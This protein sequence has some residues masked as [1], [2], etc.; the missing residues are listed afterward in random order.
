MKLTSLTRTATWKFAQLNLTHN[1]TGVVPRGGGGRRS[2]RRQ[3]DPR[4]KRRRRRRPVLQRKW[5]LGLK[6]PRECAKFLFFCELSSYILRKPAKVKSYP[7]PPSLQEQNQ[8]IKC[9]LFRP[10]RSPFGSLQFSRGKKGPHSHNSGH[11][12]RNNLYK[13]RET[14]LRTFGFFF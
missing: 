11:R 1:K 4:R 3:I 14:F 8:F 7:L 13:G 9:P 5:N 12:E 2:E 6:R 10:I